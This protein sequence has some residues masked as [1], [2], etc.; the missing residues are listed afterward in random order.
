MSRG[1][2]FLNCSTLCVYLGSHFSTSVASLSQSSSAD[3]LCVPA[4]ETVECKGQ[5]GVVRS[6]QVNVLLATLSSAGVLS[7]VHLQGWETI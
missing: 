6:Y 7:Y 3:G 2:C 1:L 5:E 4:L